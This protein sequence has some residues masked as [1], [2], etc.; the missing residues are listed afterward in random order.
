MGFSVATN[1]SVLLLLWFLNKKVGGFNGRKLINPAAKM[2]LASAVAALAL[3]IP[4]KALDQLVFDTTKTVNL[5]ALTGIASSVGIGIYLLLV[6]LLR[7][8]EVNV[9]INLLKR[10]GSW[11]LKLKSKEIIK[12]TDSI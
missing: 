1:I 10:I 9:Y 7:V 5:L 3:Y 11:Q 8:Q 4:I 12:E 2:L 6:W